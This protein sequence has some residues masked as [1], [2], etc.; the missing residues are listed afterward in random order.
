M[1]DEGK[2]DADARAWK[3]NKPRVSFSTGG[4]GNPNAFQAQRQRNLSALKNTEALLYNS[5]M[6]EIAALKKELKK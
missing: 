2:Y 3:E 1:V 6:D 5:V 4:C